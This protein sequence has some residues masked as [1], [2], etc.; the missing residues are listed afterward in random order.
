MKIFK[1]YKCYK[2]F[3]KLLSN[4]LL[5]ILININMELL[6]KYKKLNILIF[7]F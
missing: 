2:Y 5:I 3:L 6:F 7:F 4:A 1:C